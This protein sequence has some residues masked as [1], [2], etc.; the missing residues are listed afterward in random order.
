MRKDKTR[1]FNQRSIN[2]PAMVVLM[3]L[4]I[5]I[6]TGCDESRQHRVSQTADVSN[7]PK[8]AIN[9][10]NATVEEL[11]NIPYI[12]ASLAR[13]IVEYRLRHGAFRKP[14]HLILIPGI[15]DKRFRQIRQYVRTE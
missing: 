7:N 15:S 14:A 12:G 8:T 10:N 4:S 13:K 11:E 5:A 1:N 6:L 3:L 9:I 2:Y